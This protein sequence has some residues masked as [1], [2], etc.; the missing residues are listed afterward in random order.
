MNMF[1][2]SCFFPTAVEDNIK[3]QLAAANLKTSVEDVVSLYC[4]IC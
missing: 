4:L 3:E 2:P 1:H